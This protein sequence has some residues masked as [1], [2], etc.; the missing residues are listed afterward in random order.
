MKA[1]LSLFALL[2]VTL[3]AY[4]DVRSAPFVYEDANFVSENPAVTGHEGIQIGRARWLA[5]VVNRVQ[6][7][8]SPTPRAFHLGNV[9]LHLL[10]GALV[11]G[12]AWTITASLG[13][14]WLT[15]AIFLLS[16]IQTEAV[17]YVAGRTELLAAAFA[18]LA[19][20][21]AAQASRW[22]Q[23]GLV[24]ICLALAVS[25]KESAIVLVPLLCLSDVVKGRSLSPWRL[26]LLL[27][28]VALIAVSVWRFDYLSQSPL[29]LLPYAATQATALWRYLAL[30]IVPY[31]FTVDHDFELVAWGWRWLALWLVA[32]GAAVLAFL[33]MSVGSEENAPEPLWALL[34]PAA[35]PIV[36][37]L[38]WALIALAPRFVM[39]IPEVLNEHQLYFAMVGISLALGS[40]LSSWMEAV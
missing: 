4:R 37:G 16:P 31:G 23:H 34:S 9:V 3:W 29:A 33:L 13:A 21:V 38:C 5:N 10:N 22:W 14:A 2:I 17:A 30:V 40:G 7:V 39:R 35:G 36:F 19:W 20:L 8:I 25:A 6:W 12:V 26:A 32:S 24:W 15:A 11:A 18:L 1:A 28:P 27:V